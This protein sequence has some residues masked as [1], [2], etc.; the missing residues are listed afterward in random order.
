MLFFQWRRGL[1]CKTLWQHQ[2]PLHM[3]NIYI[4]LTKSIE[5]QRIS[6][7]IVLSIVENNFFSGKNCHF[8]VDDT[9]RVSNDVK[10]S[11]LRLFI[12]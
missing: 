12:F 8:W 7:F 2:N 6:I 10:R 5:F 9:S 1:G 4:L 11:N 3:K